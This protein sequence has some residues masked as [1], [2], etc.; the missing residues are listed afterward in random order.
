[1][2]STES[3]EGGVTTGNGGVAVKSAA[4]QPAFGETN[5]HS[6]DLEPTQ[7]KRSKVEHNFFFSITN[8][9]QRENNSKENFLIF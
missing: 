6:G 3:A 5:G 9:S 1:M 7:P 8:S 4:G 2:T